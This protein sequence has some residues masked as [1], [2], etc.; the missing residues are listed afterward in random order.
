MSTPIDLSTIQPRIARF[1]ADFNKEN[2]GNKID[3]IFS[4]SPLSAT[5]KKYISQLRKM[6]AATVTG[7]LA[8]E[9]MASYSIKQAIYKI[10]EMHNKLHTKVGAKP[11]TFG[12]SWVDDILLNPGK[13]ASAQ[14]V[15]SAKKLAS[16]NNVTVQEILNIA[17]KAENF[18]VAEKSD[19]YSTSE[20]TNEVTKDKKEYMDFLSAKLNKFDGKISSS[21]SGNMKYIIG[22]IKKISTDEAAALIEALENFVGYVREGEPSDWLQKAT[23]ALNRVGQAANALK[24]GT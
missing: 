20:S 2:K 8:L 10:L 24:L 4:Y 21:L 18:Y 13:Y 9:Q 6:S 7:R 12:M 16:Y 19:A 5:G 15:V 3:N 14:A 11:N 23:N 22:D 1:L 17:V